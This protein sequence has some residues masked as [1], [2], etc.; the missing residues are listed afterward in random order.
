MAIDLT[1]AVSVQDGPVFFVG[2]YTQSDL[3][4]MTGA[5]RS[6]LTYWCK[7]GVVRADSE[8]TGTGHHRLF[9]NRNVT[10]ARIA[11]ELSRIGLSVR[12]V[13]EAL[14]EWR[15]EPCDA[16]TFHRGCV[17]VTVDLRA[18]GFFARA[19]GRLRAVQRHG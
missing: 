1:Y 15:A 14:A 7:L 3:I 8:T 6:Q 4:A 2:R 13:S 11:V 19:F 16:F 17:S 9:T 5:T 10:E 12:A 18:P